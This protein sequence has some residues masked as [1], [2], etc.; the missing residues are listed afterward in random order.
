MWMK[1][2]QERKTQ[3]TGSKWEQR[4]RMTDADDGVRMNVLRAARLFTSL[5]VYFRSAVCRQISCN[6]FRNSDSSLILLSVLVIQFFNLHLRH[7]AL[8][9]TTKCVMVRVCWA[10]SRDSRDQPANRFWAFF[11]SV[12]CLWTQPKK[13]SSII[14]NYCLPWNFCCLL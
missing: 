14:L 12:S 9:K 13:K 7:Y 3:E 2:E 8:S 1:S 5:F 4:K 10:P 6:N 11:L